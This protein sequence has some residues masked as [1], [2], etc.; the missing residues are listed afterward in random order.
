MFSL[1]IAGFV[2]LVPPSTTPADSRVGDP[3]VNVAP[4]SGLGLSPSPV[5]VTPVRVPKPEP[6]PPR[7]GLGAP[8]GLIAFSGAAALAAVRKKRDDEPFYVVVHGNGGSDDDFD[9]L[10]AKMG[11]ASDRVV[12]FD[13]SNGDPDVSSTD[14]SKRVS[15]R[16]AAVALDALIRTLGVDHSNIYSIH[17]SRG[18]AVGVAM[19]AALDDGRTAPIDGYVGA[20]L[21][22]PAIDGGVVGSLQRFG[23]FT[24]LLPDNGGFEPNICVDG[25]CRDVREGLGERSGVEVIAVRNPDAVV[26]NFRDNPD[27]LRILDLNNDG[28][29]SAV[30]WLPLSPLLAAWRV[31]RA[32][33]SVLKHDAVASCISAEVALGGSCVWRDG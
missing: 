2:L 26:T 22:D 13:Y 20:A 8:V 28:G 29:V 21:L 6:R 24:T 27:G 1:L 23:R 4:G 25:V 16:D 5:V 3:V 7:R 10:L 14:A 32:H 30:W 33:A 12:A 9:T 31:S 19:I 18:G 17:H 11:I 15:T